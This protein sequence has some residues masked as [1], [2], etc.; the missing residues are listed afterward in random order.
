MNPWSWK[1]QGYFYRP[2]GPAFREQFG[3][4]VW[5]VSVDAKLGCPH[6]ESGGCLFCNE[7]AFSPSREQGRDTISGQIAEGIRR[8]KHR[9]KAQRFIAYFQPST[10]TFG[11]VELL[12]RLYREALSHPQIVGLSI[13]TRPDCLSEDVLDLLERLSRE[14]WLSLEIGLQ[15]VHDRSLEF[16]NRGHDFECFL[17]SRNRIQARGIRLGVHLILGIPGEEESHRLQC[18]K[19]IAALQLH[20]IKLHNLSVVK[21]TRLA[22][23]WERGEISLP[24]CEQYARY[25]VDFLEYQSPETIIDRISNDVSEEYLLAPEWSAMRH[26]ARNAVDQEFRRRNTYQGALYGRKE[27]F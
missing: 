2:L 4:P 8:L 25:V 11:P 26:K 10:N 19:T 6:K 16:L 20:S 1:E 17:Q 12:E 27:S 14:N 9:Y 15:S 13:G 24:D 22:T 5:K 21:N 23:L 18:A 7:I 3:E